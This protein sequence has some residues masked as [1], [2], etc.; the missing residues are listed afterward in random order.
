MTDVTI[1]IFTQSGRLIRVLKSK[2]VNGCYD[3]G[4][5]SLWDGRDE[6]GHSVARGV[7]LYTIDFK[8]EIANNEQSPYIRHESSGKIGR[9][10]KY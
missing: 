6:V 9:M 3:V 2:N 5:E 7:Y 8:Y 1:K 10:M 4:A